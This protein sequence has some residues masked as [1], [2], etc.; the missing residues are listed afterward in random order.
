[1]NKAILLL[2]FLF[3]TISN[4]QIS[5]FRNINFATA[6]NVAKL[7]KGESLRNL[8]LLSYKLTSKLKTDAE[9]FR[10]IYTWVCNNISGDSKQHNTVK[11]KR[12]KFKNDS[13]LLNKW[14]EEYK[15]KAFNTL[16]KNKKTMCTGYAYLI[17]E[18]A[19]LADIECEIVNGYGR[20]VDSN[21]ET[22]EMANHSWNAVKLNKKWY[23]CDAT[24]SSGYLNENNTFIKNYNDGYFLA[25]PNLF[26]KNHYPIN[27][28]W[29]LNDKTTNSL[30]LNAPIVYGE[31]FKH[32]I[33]PLEPRNL[34]VVT[35]KNKKV[36]F[37]FKTLNNRS[38]NNVFLIIFKGN[39]E[40]KLNISNLKNENGIL[41]FNHTF[42]WTGY[43]DVHL[44]IDTDIVASYTFKVTKK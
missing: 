40:Q 28:K 1:M 12:K 34:K 37:S 38:L 27:T 26:A 10:A 2:F 42:K 17:K 35:S 20:T 29:L 15:K 19:L 6:D 9:K 44:K 32:Q 30:F 41:T 16:L 3:F 31:T 25:N 11:Y 39:N 7:N 13:L 5:D 22:L 24:W 33:I 23:L 18:L 8:P 36:K 21:I 43:Y 4:A 14:N